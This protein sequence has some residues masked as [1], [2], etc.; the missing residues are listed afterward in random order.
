[1]TARNGGKGSNRKATTGP[2]AKNAATGRREEEGGGRT[3]GKKA[4]ENAATASKKGGDWTSGKVESL[5]GRKDAEGSDGH[6]RGGE[7]APIRKCDKQVQYRDK[8]DIAK[9][10]N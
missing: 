1:M 3:V 2:V 10:L 6:Q 7:R 4:A 5:S 9:E 8:V